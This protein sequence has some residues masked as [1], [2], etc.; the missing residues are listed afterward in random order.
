M[1]TIEKNY[2]KE[3]MNLEDVFGSYFMDL[4]FSGFSGYCEVR[5]DH[6]FYDIRKELLDMVNIPSC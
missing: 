5:E 3:Y 4:M 1:T 2:S 6:T